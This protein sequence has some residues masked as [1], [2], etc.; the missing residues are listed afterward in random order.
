MNIPKSMLA[1]LTSWNNGAGIDL[2]MW[3]GCEGRFSL[4][5]GYITI[6]WPEFVEFEGYILQAGFSESALRDFAKQEGCTRKSVEWLNNHLHLA[7]IQHRGCEDISSDKLFAL[8]SVLKEIYSAK[9]R[10][11]FPESPCIVELY[12]PEDPENLGEYQLSFWQSKH[13]LTEA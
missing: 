2:E 12:V 9:L 5:V 8:G 7:D 10:W 3:V 6:F 13:D 4:A 11:Q 1:E